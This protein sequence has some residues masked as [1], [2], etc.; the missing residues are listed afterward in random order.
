MMD[1]IARRSSYEERG[2]KFD[3]GVAVHWFFLSLLV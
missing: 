1:G 3:G 2:L